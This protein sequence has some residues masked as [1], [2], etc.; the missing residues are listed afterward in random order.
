MGNT[1][2]YLPA[3]F[4]NLYRHIEMFVPIDELREE[5]RV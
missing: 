1:A 4:E 3:T 2:E 5:D